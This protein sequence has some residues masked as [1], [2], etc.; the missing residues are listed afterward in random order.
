ML[1]LAPVSPKYLIRSDEVIPQ[2]KP[3]NY[4]KITTDL[5]YYKDFF[6]LAEIYNKSIVLINQNL[7]KILT[8]QFFRG[9]I[10]T[11]STALKGSVKMLKTLPHNAESMELHT[12]QETLMDMSKEITNN[13]VEMVK[14]ATINNETHKK[15]E[16][17]VEWM[18]RCGR[19]FKHPCFAIHIT[20]M[21]LKIFTINFNSNSRKNCDLLSY[22]DLS[23]GTNCPYVGFLDDSFDAYQ[24]ESFSS[25][26]R[27]YVLFNATV[28]K[29]H[30]VRVS[31]WMEYSNV[32]QSINKNSPYTLVELN[33]AFANVIRIDAD[34]TQTQ[35]I[36]AQPPIKGEHLVIAN[37]LLPV[38]VLDYTPI[39]IEGPQIKQLYDVLRLFMS[40]LN[41]NENLFTSYNWE[42]TKIEL[43]VPQDKCGVMMS[44]TSNVFNLINECVHYMTD[45]NVSHYFN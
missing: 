7:P 34:S 36:E 1:H 39:K 18:H 5:K 22:H 21:S 20:T 4:Y 25:N 3:N 45:D 32:H 14:A 26:M 28:K 33:T 16:Q 15:M 43:C 2:L 42:N 38:I 41:H 29:P 11:F 12:E 10:G 44:D 31:N 30:L 23:K 40:S 17:L 9:I 6:F 8:N 24:L 27:K 37:R 13:C 19:F 35:Q